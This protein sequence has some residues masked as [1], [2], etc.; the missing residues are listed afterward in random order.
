M[1][2]KRLKILIDDE[3]ESL[4]ER[5]GQIARQLLAHIEQQN[6]RIELLELKVEAQIA[7]EKGV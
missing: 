5:N 7:S 1:D 4:L 3:E 6:H 2:F